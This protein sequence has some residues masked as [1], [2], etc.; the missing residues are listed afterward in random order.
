LKLLIYQVVGKFSDYSKVRYEVDGEFYD[1]FLSS[2]AI[3]SH[4]GGDGEIV[5]ICPQSL[6]EYVQD[7]N[8]LGDLELM[9]NVF[10]EKLSNYV[11]DGNFDVL[12]VDSIGLYRVQDREVYFDSSPGNIALQIFFDMVSRLRKFDGYLNELTI[13]VDTSTGHNLY[14]PPLLEAL[15]GIIIREKLSNALKS[16]MKFLQAV[17]EPYRRDV[18]RL[19]V[20]ISEH[21]SKAFFDLPKAYCK[22]HTYIAEEIEEL[23]RGISEKYRGIENKLRDLLSNLR[24][25]FNA[26][27][28][29]TPLALYTKQLVDLNINAEN[30]EEELIAIYK[31]L[32]K[33]KVEGNRVKTVILQGKDLFNLFYSLA[34]YKWIS[35]EFKDVSEE[36][37]IDEIE[38]RFEKLYK[39]LNLS[40]NWMFLDRDLKEIKEGACKIPQNGWKTIKEIKASPSYQPKDFETLKVKEV[41]KQSNPKRN[42]FAHSGLSEDVT[43]IKVNGKIR[44]KYREDRLREIKEWLKTPGESNSSP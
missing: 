28:F 3:Y 43:M 39:K 26:I 44:V 31:N 36:P 8:L 25:A 34:L 2:T 23:K 7:F 18:N 42:F 1:G 35:C 22:L 30:L 40:L 37:T 5:Y 11:S 13:V 10:R 29:N 9:R 20:F 6:V 17:S 32:L 27:K 38:S 19:R 33:P 12:I 24:I 16:R 14:I 41:A 4:Y 15:R 21:D